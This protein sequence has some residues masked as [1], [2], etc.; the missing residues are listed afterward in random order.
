[1]N[2]LIFTK[3]AAAKELE[4]TVDMLDQL[5][6]AGQLQTTRIGQRDLITRGALDKFIRSLQT[7]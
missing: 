4:T 5:I 2:R 6:S 1:M 3:K 7:A